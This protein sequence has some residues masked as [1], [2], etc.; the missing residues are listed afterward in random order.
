MGWNGFPNSHVCT[1]ELTSFTLIHQIYNPE[2]RQTSLN[3]TSSGRQQRLWFVSKGRTS[4]SPEL[5][6]F[7]LHIFCHRLRFSII[8]ILKWDEPVF[9]LGKCPCLL[10]NALNRP[11][12][13][14]LTYI[15]QLYSNKNSAIL[16]ISLTCI[17]VQQAPPLQHHQNLK[18]CRINRLFKS[19]L[20][21]MLDLFQIKLWRI[22]HF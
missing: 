21:H 5:Q 1:W 4:F 18:V 20:L 8:F 15:Q 3:V 9:I 16:T 12:S 10:M 6:N 13:M 19:D 2:N 14:M 17:D 22:F 7:L 11:Q